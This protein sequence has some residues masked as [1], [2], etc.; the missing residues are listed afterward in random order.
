MDQ[1]RVPDRL[2]H[3]PENSQIDAGAYKRK[4]EYAGQGRAGFEKGMQVFG[5]IGVPGEHQAGG[6]AGG[7]GKERR[8]LQDQTREGKTTA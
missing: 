3:G 6:Q 4:K 2:R 7:Q 1:D 5:Q 8:L